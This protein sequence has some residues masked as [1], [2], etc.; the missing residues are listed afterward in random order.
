MAYL[1]FIKFSVQ[2]VIEQMHQLEK[3]EKIKIKKDVCNK[4]IYYCFFSIEWDSFEIQ[5]NW[6]LYLVIFSLKK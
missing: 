2:L 1:D 6:T 4:C 5:K 3:D